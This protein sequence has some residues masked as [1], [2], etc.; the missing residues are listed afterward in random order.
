VRW[1][2]LEVA[3]RF[4]ER[5]TQYWIGGEPGSFGT[6]MARTTAALP[7]G[8]LRTAPDHQVAEAGNP[9]TAKLR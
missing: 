6:P 2:F 1:D 7:I 8:T 4:T 5:A 9:T 3:T